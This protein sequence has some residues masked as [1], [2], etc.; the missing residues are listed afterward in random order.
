MTPPLPVAYAPRRAVFTPG[1]HLSGPTKIPLVVE[2]ILSNLLPAPSELPGHKP[3]Q[4]ARCPAVGNRLMSSPPAMAN[5]NTHLSHSK[6]LIS[7]STQTAAQPVLSFG[8]K[9]CRRMREVQINLLLIPANL[10][11][12]KV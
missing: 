10:L 7:P 4:L 12:S 5:H 9:T 8:R 11:I 3:A 6:P 2:V 1:E